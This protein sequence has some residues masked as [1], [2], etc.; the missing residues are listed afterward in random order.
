[1]IVGEQ[2]QIKAVSNLPQDI[3]TAIIYLGFALMF[4][5]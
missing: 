3:F 2:L 1:M 4:L 5:T